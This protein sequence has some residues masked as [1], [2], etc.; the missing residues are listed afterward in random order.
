M[1]PKNLLH[2]HKSLPLHR[3]LNRMIS[4]HASPSCFFFRFILIC[5]HL[6]LGLLS[7]F[8]PSDGS[9]KRI[10]KW[11]G[12]CVSACVYVDYINLAHGRDKGRAVVKTV[13]NIGVP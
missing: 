5:S 3:V 4:V 10:L 13:M 11:D 8:F 12:I 7:G 9:I 6:H 1:E 2:V